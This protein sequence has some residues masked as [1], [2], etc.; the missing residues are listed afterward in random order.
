MTCK[1]TNAWK[2]W[3]S[4]SSRRNGV[5]LWCR[6]RNPADLLKTFVDWGLRYKRLSQTNSLAMAI[7]SDTNMAHEIHTSVCDPDS[8]Q[9]FRRA[10]RGHG[11]P[12]RRISNKRSAYS[13]H[14][15]YRWRHHHDSSRIVH[16][17]DDSDDL[18]RDNLTGGRVG[19]TAHY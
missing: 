15:G 5:T 7:G 2:R 12:F 19:L 8:E 11:L 18:E 13:R 1:N 10:L 4:G 14:T 17:D 3:R 6:A 9:F 16:L